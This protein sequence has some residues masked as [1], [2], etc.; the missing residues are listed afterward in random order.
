MVC[1]LSEILDDIDYLWTLMIQNNNTIFTWDLGLAIC[2]LGFPAYGAKLFS[3]LFIDKYY[4]FVFLL[5]ELTY[6][7]DLVCG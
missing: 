1:H 3:I 7:V 5:I 4:L 2:V 6:D